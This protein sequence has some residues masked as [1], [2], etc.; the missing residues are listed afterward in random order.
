VYGG[1]DWAPLADTWEWDGAN[2]TERTVTVSPGD[3]SYHAMTYDRARQR[4]LLF[5]GFDELGRSSATWEWDGTT[6]TQRSPVHVPPARHSHAM[7]YDATR[8]RVVMFGGHDGSAELS[9]TWEWDGLDWTAHSPTASPGPRVNH[10]LAY[11]SLRQR[12]ILAG[13]HRWGSAPLRDTWEWDGQNWVRLGVAA[14][15]Q[16]GLSMA[17]DAARQ[18]VVGSD[19]YGAT[20]LFGSLIPA[21]VQ[22]LGVGC[23]GTSAAPRL[24]SA[25]PHLGNLGFRFALSSAWPASMCAFGLAASPQALGVGPCTL[26]LRDPIVATLTVTSG[27]GFAESSRLSIP[28]DV[29]LRGASLYAQAFVVEPGGPGLGLAFSPG[30]RIMLGD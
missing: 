7:A 12:T 17:Y 22:V 24:S 23:A 15:P 27:R 19:S 11:D 30:L 18:R 2:W 21:A 5:G 16:G 4:T 20:W 6:W 29:A 1:V 10:G 25:V 28:T 3:R 26:Y 8:Q 14:S 9:D 13:G